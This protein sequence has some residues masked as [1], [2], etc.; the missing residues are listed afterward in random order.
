[1]QNVKVNID[2]KLTSGAKVSLSD[3]QNSK[4]AEFVYNLLFT[5]PKRTYQKH[6]KKRS[7]TPE[8]I[9]LV[10]EA[11]AEKE[12][13]PRSKAYKHLA[14]MFNR[15]RAAIS[16]KAVQIRTEEKANYFSNP[17]TINRVK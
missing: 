6:S 5:L 4:V 11:M 17:V 3:E 15:T 16:Q 13:K 1:M 2:I 8:E 14:S 12:G 7:W 9:A 10:K